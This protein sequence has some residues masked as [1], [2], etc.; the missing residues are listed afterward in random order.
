[1]HLQ[2]CGHVTSPANQAAQP[3]KPTPNTIPPPFINF[4]IPSL[5]EKEEE[6]VKSGRKG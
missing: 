2:E 1:M 3:T 5:Q 4:N 6:N